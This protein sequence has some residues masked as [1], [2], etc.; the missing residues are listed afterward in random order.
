MDIRAEVE[1]GRR[2]AAEVGARVDGL[3]S[4]VTGAMEGTRQEMRA[5][6]EEGRRQVAEVGTR[7]DRLRDEVAGAMEGTRQE[8]RA[9][10][11]EVGA[12]MDGLRSEVAGAMEGTRQEIRAEMEE[13]RRQV[14]EVGARV[15]GLRDEVAGAMEGTRQEFRAEMEEGRRQAAEV[16]ARMDGLRSEI[17]GAIETTRQEVRAEVAEVGARVDALRSESTDSIEALRAATEFDMAH[18]R[19]EL[20]QAQKEFSE[21]LARVVEEQIEHTIGVRLQAI[22]DQMRESVRDESLSA[23]ASFANSVESSIEERL[24]AFRAEVG[25]DHREMSEL[26]A[27]LEGHERNLLELVLALGQRCMQAADWMVPAAPS[28]RVLAKGAGGGGGGGGFTP[29]THIAP[30]GDER[31]PTFAS[32]KPRRPWRMPV[33]SGFAIAAASLIALHYSGM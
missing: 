7:V 9:E 28:Q 2:Q 26:C 3:R 16:G 31:L 19:T 18:L 30:A 5:E 14:A 11:A 32:L 20:A 25:G 23:Y 29:E 15:D 27:R 17:A 13:G 22:Q 33:V 8:V 4:E 21:T 24:R 6:L 12:R 1:E 10:V